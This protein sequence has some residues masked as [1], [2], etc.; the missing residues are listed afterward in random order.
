VDE[1][2]AITSFQ[3]PL[4]KRIRS[5]KY[6]KYRQR[7][8]VFW[9]EGIRNVLEALDTGWEIEM[10]VWSPSLLRSDLARQKLAQSTLPTVA[11]SEAV[12]ARLSDSELPQGL[13]ALVRIPQRGLDHISIGPDAL[14]IV[15]EQ[16]QDR[17]NVGAVV[18]T[19]DAAGGCGVVLVGQAVD[20]FDPEA[21]RTAMGALFALPVVS[22]ELGEFLEWARAHRLHLMGTSARAEKDFRQLPYPRPLALVFGNERS[23]LSDPLRQ[24]VHALAR[25]PI[26]GRAN[27]LNLGAAVAIM[28]YQAQG[29]W[30]ASSALCP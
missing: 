11:V 6:K 7:Q 16:P 18:R 5:L 9:A 12:F 24:A 3:N 27:S 13:G 1:Q 15:L 19:A 26:L 20:P 29:T 23:G 14:L 4:V 30:Q 2:P 25:I 8:G 17:G 28:A 10:L 21:L 22:A